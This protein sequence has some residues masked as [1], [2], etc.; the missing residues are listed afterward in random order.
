M[1]ADAHRQ[2]ALDDEQA[3]ADLGD[4]AAKP[5]IRPTV[6]EGH[7][8]A[9]FHWIA[10]GCQTKHGKH[11]ERE[12]GLVAFLGSLGESSLAERWRALE[13]IRNAAW[14]TSDISESAVQSAHDVWQQIRAWALG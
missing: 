2:A 9:A 4:P 14:N 13:E 8:G 12:R 5:Y 1:L 11:K 3:L 10:Y 6:I 7:W